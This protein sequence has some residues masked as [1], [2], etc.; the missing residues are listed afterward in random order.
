MDEILGWASLLNYPREPTA[1]RRCRARGTLISMT[2]DGSESDDEAEPL[3]EDDQGRESEMAG[4]T[5]RADVRA[6]LTTRR[7]ETDS[8][9]IDGSSKA[10]RESVERREPPPDDEANRIVSDEMRHMR[11]EK[12]AKTFVRTPRG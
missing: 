7:G 12:R 6:R 3:N 5:R 9:V 8:E 10:V 4:S 1:F 11:A 2:V